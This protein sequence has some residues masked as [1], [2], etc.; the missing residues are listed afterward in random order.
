MTR[1]K[2]KIYTVEFTLNAKL[3][4]IIF[5]CYKYKFPLQFMLSFYE[6]Y[7]DSSLFAL[8]A[9]TCSRKTKLTDSELVDIVEQSRRLYTQIQQGIS[10]NIK[11]KKILNGILE[12]ELPDPP[13]IDHIG[14][15]VEYDEF[16]NNYLLQ[17][18]EDIYAPTTKL[19]MSSEDIYTELK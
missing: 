9:L 18:I 10:I 3:L 7:G 12:E 17:N 11:R 16:I 19:K 8:K 2:N 5:I 14:F 1:M 4:A 13:C 15:S 6:L